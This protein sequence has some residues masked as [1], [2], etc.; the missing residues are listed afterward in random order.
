MLKID[1]KK[2]QAAQVGQAAIELA[3]FG[4]ILDFYS[5]DDCALCRWQ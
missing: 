2:A 4:A 3:V 1:N 5:W